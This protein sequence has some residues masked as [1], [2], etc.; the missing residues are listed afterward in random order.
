MNF[1][2][3]DRVPRYDIFLPDFITAWRNKYKMSDIVNIYDF[4][5]EIDI[6]IVA[7]DQFGPYLSKAGIEKRETGSYYERDSWGRLLH[8]IDNTYFESVIETPVTNKYD[9]PAF[10]APKSSR[11]KK[12]MNW[13]N[14]SCWNHNCMVSGVLGLFMGCCKLRGEVNFLIDLAEDPKYC[15]YLSEKIADYIFET[16]VYTAENTNTKETAL[17][18][19]DEFSSKLS[20]M[21][22]PKTFEK[23]FLPVYKKLIAK[24]K[25]VGIK[26][27]ILHCDGNSLPLLDMI[28]EAGFTGLQSL[29]PTAGMWLPDVKKKYGNQL[30]LIGGMCNIET[31]AKGTK[32]DIERQAA[33][34]LEV[35]RDGGV[36][37]GTHS[38]DFDIPVENY[39]IY[40][41]F[42]INH[43]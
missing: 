32:Q 4:Y 31:L 14:D 34:L 35:S 6:G 30:V 23:V 5:S 18:I 40:H 13:A 24:Y 15:L 26:H 37:L 19:Y 28:I 41:R 20:P 43:A 36:I 1:K 22:S 33:E 11:R 16:G 12:L 29:A 7:A 8:R 21:F 10:E 27:I 9:E 42:M 17:W 38:I 25:E 3:P 2:K 39:D